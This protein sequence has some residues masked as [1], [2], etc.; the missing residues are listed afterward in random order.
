M[1]GLLPLLLCATLRVEAAPASLDVQLL[2]TSKTG[3]MKTAQALIKRGAHINARDANGATPLILAAP[4]GPELMDVLL[5]NGA[6]IRARDKWG[7]SCLGYSP[8]S[9]EYLAKHG[10]VATRNDA[11]ALSDWLEND[12]W[13]DS[14]LQDE[15]VCSEAKTLLSAGMNLNSRGF[16]ENGT[17]PLMNAVDSR[18]SLVPFLLSLG[19]E[20]NFP[21][22]SGRTPLIASI[23]PLFSFD[24][25]PNEA[26][27]MALLEHGAKVNT[28]GPDGET[29]LVMVAGTNHVSL[30]RE[31]IARGASPNIRNKYGQTALMRAA[32]SGFIE[33]ARLLLAS[34][35]L[36]NLADAKG[37]TALDY[38]RSREFIFFHS[39]VAI[40]VTGSNEKVDEEEVE[41]RQKGRLEIQTLLETQ[42]K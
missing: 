1:K 41:R 33:M 42:I 15:E 17:T 34:G 16:D 3:D 2:Q 39:P 29:A 24:T 26:V 36:P 38:A 5:E 22:G 11:A 7:F 28:R 25:P 20:P 32:T 27:A 35:A 30:A 37:Q 40:G 10:A 8:E 21:D 9:A 6:D 19:A 31:L 14:D 18:P 23:S 13:I 12:I 4:S